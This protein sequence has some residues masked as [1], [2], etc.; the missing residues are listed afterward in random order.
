MILSQDQ[1]R[2]RIKMYEKMIDIAKHLEKIN[3]FNTLMSILAGIKLAPIHRLK[4]IQKKVTSSKIEVLERLVALMFGEGSMK[5]YRRQLAQASLPCL[6]YVGTS[7]TDLTFIEDGNSDKTGELI[8]FKKRFLFNLEMS[9]P[10]YT[11]LEALPALEDKELWEISNYLEPREKKK[12][13]DKSAKP[14][15]Q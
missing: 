10:I 13:S 3:N 4:K 12:T 1:G 11:F 15:K 8:N 14:S 2:Q 6:P 7:L 5:D 9:E